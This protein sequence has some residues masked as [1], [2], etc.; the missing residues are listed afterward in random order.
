[1]RWWGGVW[2]K[3]NFCE[4]NFRVG[5]FGGLEVWFGGGGGLNYDNGLDGFSRGFLIRYA[6]NGVLW[7]LWEYGLIVWISSVGEK[8]LESFGFISWGWVEGIDW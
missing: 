3:R 6:W 8:V 4:K 5:R 7:G 2:G 1:M